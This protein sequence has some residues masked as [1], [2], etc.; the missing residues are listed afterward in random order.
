VPEMWWLEHVGDG[1]RYS[2][3]FGGCAGYRECDCFHVMVVVVVVV[4]VMVV[5]F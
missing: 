5:V 3:C 4:V 2:V 1:G